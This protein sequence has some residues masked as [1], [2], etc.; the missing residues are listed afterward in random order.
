MSKYILITHYILI[1]YKGFGYQNYKDY[2]G[3]R[4]CHRRFDIF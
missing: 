1:S 3:N 2:A 4:I